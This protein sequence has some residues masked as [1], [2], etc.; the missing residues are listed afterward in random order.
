MKDDS[1][2]AFAGIWDSWRSPDGKAVASCAILTTNP[3]ELVADVHDRMPLILHPNHYKRLADCDST[4]QPP[5]GAS[6]R[7]LR[8][9]T[10][11]EVSGLTSCERCQE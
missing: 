8:S 1:L 7:S 2:F 5:L 11:E 6:A 9:W 4:K 3:N 10:D